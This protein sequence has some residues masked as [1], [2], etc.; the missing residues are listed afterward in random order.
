VLSRIQSA[1]AIHSRIAHLLR[2]TCPYCYG[3]ATAAAWDTR[4]VSNLRDWSG[5]IKPERFCILRFWLR[6]G[7]DILVYLNPHLPAGAG[8]TVSQTHLG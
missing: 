8:L 1:L 6:G 7:R 2:T 3:P 5:H 4:F